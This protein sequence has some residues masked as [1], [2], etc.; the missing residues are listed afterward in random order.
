VAA[1]FVQM[2]GSA[3]LSDPPGGRFPEAAILWVDVDGGRTR[4]LAGPPRGIDV[5]R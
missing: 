1:A 3:P 4:L 2:F 5:G